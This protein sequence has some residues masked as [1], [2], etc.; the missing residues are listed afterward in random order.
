MYLMSLTK[1]GTELTGY[2]LNFLLSSVC[3][4]L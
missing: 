4:T 3:L 1:A 2:T